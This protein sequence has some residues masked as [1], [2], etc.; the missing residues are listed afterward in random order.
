MS[1]CGCGCQPAPSVPDNVI[2]VRTI[3]PAQRHALIF[4]RFRA[5]DTGDTLV[6]VNDHDPRP[7]KHQFEDVFGHKVAW[8]YLQQGPDLWKVKLTRQSCC[9]SCA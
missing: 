8:E 4:D 1:G 6:L 9:G 3:P 5:L 2:D 7:L